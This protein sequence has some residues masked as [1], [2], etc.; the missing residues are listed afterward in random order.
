MRHLLYEARAS[1]NKTDECFSTP[2]NSMHSFL[3]INFQR[4]DMYC[5]STHYKYVLHSKC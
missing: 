5:F 4:N 1:K 3:G 2:L